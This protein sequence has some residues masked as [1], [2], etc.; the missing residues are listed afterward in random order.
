MHFENEIAVCKNW[1]EYDELV[2][3]SIHDKKA[4]MDF[5]IKPLTENNIRNCLIDTLRK[6]FCAVYG[7]MNIVSDN[8]IKEN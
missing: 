6:Q 8:N 7:R 4:E 2:L 3:E 5:V 1:I